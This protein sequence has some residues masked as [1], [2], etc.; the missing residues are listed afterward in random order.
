MAEPDF[1][2]INAAIMRAGAKWDSGPTIVSE[3]YD[4]GASAT[5]RFGLSFDPERAKR[6]V[7]ATRNAESALFKVVAPP[8]PHL[9]WRGVNGGD[10]VTSIKDQS[11]C[12]SCVAFA[13]CAAIES[14]ILIGTGNPGGSI[15]LS[16]AHLFYCGAVNA[17]ES[18]WFYTK[19]LAYAKKPGIGLEAD[20]PYVPGNQPCRNIKP[21]VT[22]PRYQTAASQI[23]RKQALQ[24]GPVIGGFRVFQDFYT[25]RSG[26]YTHV[27]GDFLGWHAVCII[28]YD[29]NDQCWIAKNSWGT[30]WGETGFFR[31]GFGECGIDSDVL[32]Y[33]PEIS[34][35][36]SNVAATK[37]LRSRKKA[38]A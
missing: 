15:D 26:I 20:F 4:A 22:V 36:K 32:F 35:L 12:G 24:K 7:V 37:P 5:E 19:A 27:T 34:L 28:G 23:A 1:D 30:G 2:R 8:P 33:D 9:D 14:R 11:N 18:G 21:V 6:D 13:T 38:T 10:Y 17:C 3:F 25:Y 29:D 31:I 16:E